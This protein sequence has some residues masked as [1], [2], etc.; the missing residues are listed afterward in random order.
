MVRGITCLVGTA[1][2]QLLLL[3]ANELINKSKVHNRT[4]AHRRKM[5]MEEGSVPS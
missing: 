3:K 5:L 1:I 2:T 4:N